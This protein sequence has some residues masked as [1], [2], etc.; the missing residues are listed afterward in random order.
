MGE[1]AEMMLDG[2]LCEGCGTYIDDNGGDGIPRYC[3]DECARG[4]GMQYV[5]SR[6]RSQSHPIR[7][8]KPV[9]CPSCPRRFC[10]YRDLNNHR[11]DKH[12]VATAMTGPT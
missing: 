10:S 11:R 8:P 5:P 3:S 7:S 12:G 2:T 4:R 9:G 6:E 1:I